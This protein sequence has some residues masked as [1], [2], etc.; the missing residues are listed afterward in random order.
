MRRLLAPT[1]SS[2]SFCQS[3]P[4]LTVAYTK[5]DARE[6]VSVDSEDQAKHID[7]SK[8]AE[9]RSPLFLKLAD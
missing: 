8:P 2:T 9:N 7:P 6:P 3:V 4:V 5:W 1:T